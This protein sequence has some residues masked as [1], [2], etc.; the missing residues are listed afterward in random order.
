MKH[1][2]PQLNV[3]VT[4]EEL[5]SF[6]AGVLIRQMTNHGD[7]GRPGRCGL[8]ACFELFPFQEVRETHTEQ[9]LISFKSHV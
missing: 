3:T 9:G 8:C 5:A 2:D 6:L 7:D 4:R 1:H